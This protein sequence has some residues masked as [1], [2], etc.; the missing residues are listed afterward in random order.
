MPAQNQPR[1]RSRRDPLEARRYALI[2]Q[3][4]YSALQIKHT[5]PAVVWLNKVGYDATSGSARL[6]ALAET[7]RRTDCDLRVRERHIRASE[8]MGAEKL[9]RVRA[10]RSMVRDWLKNAPKSTLAK[11]AADSLRKALFGSATRLQGTIL[12][13]QRAFGVWD[14]VGGAIE[15]AA[16]GADLRARGATLLAELERYARQTADHKAE[17]SKEAVAAIAADRALRA[18]M[19]EVRRRWK[20]AW[21]L[22]GG[23]TFPEFD[24]W[25]AAAALPVRGAPDAVAEA[26]ATDNAPRSAA[27]PVSNDGANDGANATTPTNDATNDTPPTVLVAVTL[28]D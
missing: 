4:A 17:A 14:E 13:L 21:R 1:R 8:V 16:L 11:A 20:Q 12:L 22:S 28:A 24:L 6:S 25:I 10:W 23:R 2:E 18:E 27:E 3:G 19:A 5:P 9:P 7:A 26:D 15:E